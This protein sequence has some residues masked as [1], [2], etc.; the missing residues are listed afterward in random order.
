M[1]GNL[2]KRA[3]FCTGW[4]VSL[5]W[6]DTKE[7]AGDWQCQYRR[8]VYLGSVYTAKIIGKYFFVLFDYWLEFD[9]RPN[10]IQ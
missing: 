3:E 2:S 10:S 7:F 1:R 9:E 5:A 6:G 4:V 8:A